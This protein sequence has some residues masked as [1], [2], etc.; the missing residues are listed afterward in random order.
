MNKLE[1]IRAGAGSGKTTELCRIVAEAVS[2][3]LDPS[4]ILA[5]TFT[6][7]AAAELKS[8]MQAKLL[9]LDG[10]SDKTPFG[11][12]DRFDLA[13]IGTVHSIAIRLLSRYAIEM[14][15]SPTL[16]V[17]DE[18]GSERTLNDLLGQVQEE[19]WVRLSDA[20]MRLSVDD[21]QKRILKLLEI[22]RGNRINDELFAIK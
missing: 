9:G 6:K 18:S 15:L 3:K 13:A 8:R 11:H 4:R 7:K 12:A 20:A 21:L 10:E 17:L 1:V 19:H 22:K 14:G 16:E 2:M 5:T